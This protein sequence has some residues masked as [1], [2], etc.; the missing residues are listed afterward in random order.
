MS[1]QDD[2]NKY[3]IGQI[4]AVAL[5]ASALAAK[6]APDAAD[7]LLARCAA[8]REKADQGQALVPLEQ[9]F[10]SVEQTVLRCLKQVS[11]AE[12]IRSVSGPAQH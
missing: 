7:L 1:M 4:D 8:L 2:I 3:L 6:L 11:D 9:G 5:L 12:K 10:L